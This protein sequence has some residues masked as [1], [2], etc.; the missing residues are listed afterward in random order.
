MSLS[1]QNLLD[2][3][4]AL[5]DSILLATN[6]DFSIPSPFHFT[7][8]EDFWANINDKTTKATVETTLIRAC[9]IRYLTFGYEGEEDQ[10]EVDGPVLLL[11]YELTVFHEST[12]ERLD[13]SAPLDDFNKRVSKTNHEHVTAVMSLAGLFLGIT[14]LPTLSAFSVAEINSLIQ[15]DASEENVECKYIPG[16]TGD[17]TILEARVRIQLPC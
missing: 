13:Q 6:I 12:M 16:V 7:S 8:K 2:I 3:A 9:W 5:N 10:R 17:Q 15:P 1:S 4:E 14:P 11:D